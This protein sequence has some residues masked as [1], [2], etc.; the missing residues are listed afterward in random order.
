[1]ETSRLRQLLEEAERVG[2]TIPNVFLPPRFRKLAE[3][4]DLILLFDEDF[5]L[6]VRWVGERR[7]QHMP[8]TRGQALRLMSEALRYMVRY[9]E[10]LQEFKL[11]VD[12]FAEEPL[13]K[14]RYQNG[15]SQEEEEAPRTAQVGS[16]EEGL[17]VNSAG[18]ESPC[19][20][21]DY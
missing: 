3:G 8:L 19:P 21:T 20:N 7:S 14:E 5:T 4:R 15:G 11:F 13:D 10:N 12:E 2:F 1:M 9:E 17:A 6:H 18:G 16:E